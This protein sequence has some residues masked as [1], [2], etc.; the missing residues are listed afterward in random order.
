MF[1]T[2]FQKLLTEKINRIIQL[3]G[4][5]PNFFHIDED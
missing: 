4:G 2:N 1:M 5:G 3:L